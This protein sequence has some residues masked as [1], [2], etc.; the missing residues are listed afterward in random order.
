MSDCWN[1][2]KRSIKLLWVIFYLFLS[3]CMM[4]FKVKSLFLW[5]ESGGFKESN[6]RNL[7]WFRSFRFKDTT[8]KTHHKCFQRWSNQRNPS[9]GGRRQRLPWSHATYVFCLSF[10]WVKYCTF[11]SKHLS[12]FLHTEKTLLLVSGHLS[13]TYSHS[14]RWFWCWLLYTR[15]ISPS[16]LF[17]SEQHRHLPPR[18]SLRSLFPSIRPRASTHRPPPPP[19]LP[20]S[21]WQ[22]PG[23]DSFIDTGWKWPHISL[24]KVHSCCMP[25]STHTHT[26]THTQ[27]LHLTHI[28]SEPAN[29][30]SET[31]SSRTCQIKTR[32]WNVSSCFG[33]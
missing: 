11:I 12:F 25:A 13:N 17:I 21:P 22:Q 30:V 24:A 10:D 8:W 9:R 3:S 32:K 15:L 2:W 6:T 14:Y 18:V 26:H 29:T 27:W 16:F 20:P 28:C 1:I 23:G 31:Q 5:M 4:I 33:R 19:L 7:F